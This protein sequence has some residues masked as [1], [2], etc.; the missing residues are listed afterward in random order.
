MDLAPKVTRVQ[1]ESLTL[2]RILSIFAPQYGAFY[3]TYFGEALNR[4]DNIR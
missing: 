3:S 1:N 2:R 4:I